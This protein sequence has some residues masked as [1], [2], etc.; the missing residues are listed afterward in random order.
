MSNK[1]QNYNF[2]GE[3]GPISL[4]KWV[5]QLPGIHPARKEYERLTAEVSRLRGLIYKYVDPC[6]VL[7]EEE[8]EI[9]A[10]MDAVSGKQEKTCAGCGCKWHHD[11]VWCPECAIKHAADQTEHN[12]KD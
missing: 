8:N 7:P 9:M 2:G 11:S 10:C 4:E 1:E 6:A 5:G 3:G 12:P